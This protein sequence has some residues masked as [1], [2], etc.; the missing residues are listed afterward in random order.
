MVTDIEVVLC[1][2]WAV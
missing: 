2:Y 1:C